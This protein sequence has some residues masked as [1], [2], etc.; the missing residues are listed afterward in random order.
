MSSL[1]ALT[2]QNCLLT[3]L[4]GAGLLERPHDQMGREARARHLS[5]LTLLQPS[6]DLPHPALYYI[7][8]CLSLPMGAT[9]AVMMIIAS[10][11]NPQKNTK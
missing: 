3:Y 1:E 2:S 7:T 6:S 9:A 5:S 8:T 10:P 11:Q 4:Q